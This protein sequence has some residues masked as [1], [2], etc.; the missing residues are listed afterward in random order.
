MK[1][2]LP[3]TAPR[4]AAPGQ[5]GSR[6]R[7]ARALFTLAFA[8]SF[9]CPGCLKK[10]REP[11]RPLRPWLGPDLGAIAG[12]ERNEPFPERTLL[13]SRNETPPQTLARID[14]VFRQIGSIRETEQEW[15]LA[16]VRAEL[17]SIEAEWRRLRLG[18]GD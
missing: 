15:R 7:A 12:K 1:R 14:E 16:P 18:A 11:F 4:T 3:A 5:A 17:D 13:E 10:E 2:I 8:A 9:I 6:R